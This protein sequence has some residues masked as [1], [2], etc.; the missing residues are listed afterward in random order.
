M[1]ANASVRWNRAVTEPSGGGDFCSSG[2][3]H[4]ILSTRCSVGWTKK[5]SAISAE[6]LLATCSFVSRLDRAASSAA[7]FICDE[8]R[9]GRVRCC[10][11]F[12]SQRSSYTRRTYIAPTSFRPHTMHTL[13]CTLQTPLTLPLADLLL[14][15][16]RGPGATSPPRV[17]PTGPP[18]VQPSA[19]PGFHPTY[20][21][22][23]D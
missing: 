16:R 22:G 11:F 1:A 13:T 18:R 15:I 5:G 4:F 3:G 21:H 6:H 8:A 19:P 10:T 12:V 23:S 20:V 2:L 17:S 14:C 9:I 7:I